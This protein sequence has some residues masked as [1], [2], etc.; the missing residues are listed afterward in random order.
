MYK[1]L[2][3]NLL[4]SKYPYDYKRSEILEYLSEQELQDVE[5]TAD[6]NGVCAVT[7]DSVVIITSLADMQK[8][9]YG[10]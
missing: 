1:Y 8:V 4:N 10:F 6:R 5:D 3:I 2:F 7:V 9:D